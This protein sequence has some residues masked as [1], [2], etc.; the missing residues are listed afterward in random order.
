MIRGIDN[1]E[2]PTHQITNDIPF[3]LGG[4]ASPDIQEIGSYN[5]YRSDPA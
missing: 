1:K 3:G 5:K 2:C 4:P